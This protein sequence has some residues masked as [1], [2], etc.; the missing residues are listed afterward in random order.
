M[1]KLLYT[2]VPPIHKKLLILLNSW[3]IW[4][5]IIIHIV[6]T[7]IYLW[8]GGFFGSQWG[9]CQLLLFA[10][11]ILYSLFAF[12]LIWGLTS[13]RSIWRTIFTF[14]S[15]SLFLRER[16]WGLRNPNCIY[17]VLLTAMTS[18]CIFLRYL[19][20]RHRLLNILFRC[21]YICNWWTILRMITIN[22][23]FILFALILFQLI[24]DWLMRL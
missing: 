22:Y 15:C 2:N 16:Y 10:L 8:Y 23:K 13:W 12:F 18:S 19:L 14:I 21:N 11:F 9:F 6:I 1:L 5:G 4:D 7:F 24:L 17:N 3:S 20:I